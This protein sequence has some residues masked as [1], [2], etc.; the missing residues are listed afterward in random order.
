ME[1]MDLALIILFFIPF[2]VKGYFHLKNGGKAFEF[3]T[4]EE[5]KEHQENI[6]SFHKHHDYSDSSDPSSAL[7]H[8]PFDP[9]H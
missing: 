7:Y 6:K 8:S 3:M 1:G 9:R 4:Y 2:V 5:L